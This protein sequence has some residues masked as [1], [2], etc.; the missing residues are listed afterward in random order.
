MYAVRAQQVSDDLEF[1]EIGPRDHHGT[2]VDI[3]HHRGVDAHRGVG[4]RVD[5][6]ALAQRVGHTAFRDLLPFPDALSRI[7]TFHTAVGVI[8][9]VEHAPLQSGCRHPDGVPVIA[10]FCLLP[11]Q[12]G[13]GTIEQAEGTA[14]GN[15]GTVVCLLIADGVS[16]VVAAFRDQAQ[17]HQPALPALLQLTAGNGDSSRRSAVSDFGTD[18]T[19]G[20]RCLARQPQR[21]THAIVADGSL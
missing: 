10:L 6:Q 5:G 16:V 14:C 13:I 21:S 18:D 9:V 2:G 8:P 19:G 15:H 12:Q 1:F 3:V 7:A 11:A 17:R 4:A 20:H